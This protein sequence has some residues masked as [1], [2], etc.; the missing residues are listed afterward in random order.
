MSIVCLFSSFVLAFPCL[1]ILFPGHL[2]LCLSTSK[3]NLRPS[4]ISLWRICWLVACFGTHC[5]SLNLINITWYSY[6]Y[7]INVYFYLLDLTLLED[8][9]RCITI[10]FKSLSLEI[11]IRSYFWDNKYLLNVWYFKYSLSVYYFPDTVFW[12]RGTV[13][14]Q[15]KVSTLL[16]MPCYTMRLM[17][18]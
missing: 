3:S 10:S 11:C 4:Q 14:S 18:Q 15:T 2:P 13:M 17:I 7:K 6:N 12:T 9:E 8:S 16:E 5:E 1:R